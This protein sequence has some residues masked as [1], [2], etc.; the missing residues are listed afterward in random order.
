MQRDHP[1]LCFVLVV[2]FRMLW[3]RPS[4]HILCDHYTG[5]NLTICQCLWGKFKST[6]TNRVNTVLTD[7]ITIENC[8]AKHLLDNLWDAKC[9]DTYVSPFFK[10]CAYKHSSYI[11]FALS[12]NNM[13]HSYKQTRRRCKANLPL[14]A[15]TTWLILSIFLSCSSHHLP[16]NFSG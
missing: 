16:L 6:L 11:P 5:K 4:L 10:A 14:C 7:R 3:F 9:D 13:Q 2:T 8:A 15:C 12:S 1:L